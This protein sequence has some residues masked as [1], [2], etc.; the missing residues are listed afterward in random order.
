M[1]FH[2]SSYL[3]TLCHI[4]QLSNDEWKY[5]HFQK[6]H[7]TCIC[8]PNSIASFATYFYKYKPLY[9]RALVTAQGRILRGHLLK[10]WQGVVALCMPSS[11]FT[12]GGELGLGLL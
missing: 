2:L 6:E 9:C 4:N 5:R 12:E 1:M 3:K 7:L 11:R 8:W 10:C